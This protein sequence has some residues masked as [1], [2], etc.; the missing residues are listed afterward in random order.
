METKNNRRK[1]LVVDDI[2][3]NLQVLGNTLKENGYQLEF[4][5]DGPSAIKW[6][7]KTNFDLILLD[8][9]MPGMT[10][11]EV[12]KHIRANEKYN[13]TPIIF[14]TAK[15]ETES[16]VEGFNVGGQDYITKPF[17]SEELLA[18]VKTH[19]ELKKAKDQLKNMNTILEDKVK[20]R[21]L[22]L[23]EANKK[24]QNLDQAKTT[25]LNII[26]HEI[27]TP[28]NG[29]MGGLELIKDFVIDDDVIEFLEMLDISSKRLERFSYTALDISNFIAKG[30]QQLKKESVLA[31]TFIQEIQDELI[32]KIQEKNLAVNASYPKNLELIADEKHLA[33]VNL[34]I[35]D[36]A[37][38]YSEANG[39][40]NIK[41]WK[42]K[43][44]TFLRF[45]DTGSGFKEGY[46]IDNILPFE[47]EEHV[48]QNPGLSLYLSRL[49]IEAHGGRIKNGNNDDKGA[50]VE[51]MLPI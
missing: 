24:L 33:K 27:R 15:V 10:G 49:I 45:E 25:F 13:D 48:D 29:I 38:K 4:A 7:E 43:N 35:F 51:Y 50:F 40:I 30:Q 42:E 16:V 20:E 41:A 37:I 17:E 47:N 21:T 22:Q 46:K 5:L 19:L 23:I 14:L 34:A 2:P 11:Y 31:E 28:L 6:T 39:S 32:M 1:I 18:R 9:M 12:C 44:Y 26:S 8:I 36:N 3:K